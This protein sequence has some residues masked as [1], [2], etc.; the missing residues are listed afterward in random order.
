MTTYFDALKALVKPEMVS[1]ASTVVGESKSNISKAVSSII[2][3]LLGVMLKK[4]NTPQIKNILEESGN[5]NLLLDVDALWEER[6]TEDQR[7][8]GDDFLQHLL[9]DKAADFTDPIAKHT[10]ISNVATNRLIALI[11]PIFTGF[12]GN[13]MVKENRSIHEILSEISSEKNLFADHIPADLAKNFGLTTIQ[14][15]TT[16]VKDKK[17]N[18]WI[19][20]IVLLLVLL[21]LFFGWRSC[22]NDKVMD[23]YTETTTD[24]ISQGR[25]SQQSALASASATNANTDR[26]ANMQRDTTNITLPNGVKL[27]VYKDG[28][29]EKMVKY[30]NSDD[31]KKATENDLKEKWFE[32]DNIRFEF[33]SGTELQSGSKSQIDNIIAILK[34]YKNAKIKIG[35]FADKKGTEQANMDVSKQ[36]AKTIEDL[37][38]KG[39]VGSQVVRTEGYGDEYAKHSASES[40]AKRAEDR[41]IALR[42]VK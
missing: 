24:T 4:G 34:Q 20:W 9:G 18:S 2:A 1:M 13:K 41:D 30:L 11:A 26:N 15:A 38:D 35:G 8:I 29:E 37:L 23:T 42:F 5:L 28:T 39:G 16:P 21:L 32:F 33:G 25:S 7:R 19:I 14:G 6:P 12:L 22:R 36:R 40:D 3:G 27:T 17:S 10:G 31:Y